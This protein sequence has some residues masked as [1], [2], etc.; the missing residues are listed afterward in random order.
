MEIE[1]LIGP[2]M[3]VLSMTVQREHEAF[4]KGVAQ[5]S[6]GLCCVFSMGAGRLLFVAAKDRAADLSVLVD[7]L[8]REL[9][10]C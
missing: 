9:K 4:V 1:E 10:T 3:S 8:E 5:A 7:D 6:D 2:G